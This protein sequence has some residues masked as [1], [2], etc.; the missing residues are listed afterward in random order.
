MYSKLVYLDKDKDNVIY[1]NR[2]IVLIIK[3]DSLELNKLDKIDISLIEASNN[4]FWSLNN[5]YRDILDG[6]MMLPKD[7]LDEIK[8]LLSQRKK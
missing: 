1:G 8:I 3:K 5:S 2:N 6:I 4:N 7:K